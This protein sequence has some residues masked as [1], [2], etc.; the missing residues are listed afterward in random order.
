MINNVM[1]MVSHES[2]NTVLYECCLSGNKSHG[3]FRFRLVNSR[4]EKPN[5]PAGFNSACWGA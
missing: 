2:H 1:F 4:S 5:F 3:H